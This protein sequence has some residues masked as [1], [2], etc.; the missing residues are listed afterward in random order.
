MN[1]AWILYFLD[2]TIFM[3]KQDLEE[4]SLQSK[5]RSRETKI[6]EKKSSRVGL[7]GSYRFER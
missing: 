1:T 7:S 5:G 6:D 2:G 4:G 3:T